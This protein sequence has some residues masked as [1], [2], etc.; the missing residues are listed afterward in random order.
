MT[1]HGNLRAIGAV[2]T[3]DSRS[4]VFSA[5]YVVSYAALSLPALAAGLLAPAWGLRTTSFAFIG[6]VGV[7]SAVALAHARDADSAGTAATA[8]SA[9]ANIH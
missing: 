2:T 8:D 4:Q 7:L 5:V 3:A 6:F 1:F 9:T